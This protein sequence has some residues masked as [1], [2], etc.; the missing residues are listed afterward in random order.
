[1]T[2][3]AHSDFLPD[4]QV[5]APAFDVYFELLIWFKLQIL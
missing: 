4:E 3:K 5:R 2:I 1:M